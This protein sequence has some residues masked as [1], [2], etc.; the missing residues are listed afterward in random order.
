MH[1][2]EQEKRCKNLEIHNVPENDNENLVDVVV[3]TGK[4]LGVAIVENDI[5][6]IYRSY[7]KNKEKPRPIVVQFCR[8]IKRDEI[9]NLRRQKLIKA[10]D[11]GKRGDEKIYINE[12]LSP[13]FKQKLWE[14]KN[15][16]EIN[17]KI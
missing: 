11:V 5:D 16:Y 7:N 2:V 14:V 17:M 13:F 3:M 9:Y 6:T 10:N 15:K 4:K 8:K 1:L 12:S